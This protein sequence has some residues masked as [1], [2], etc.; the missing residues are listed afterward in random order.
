C[1]QLVRDL[2]PI[3]RSLTGDGVRETLAY[4]SRQLPGLAVHEIP[5]GTQVF[6][7]VVP[8]EWSIRDAYVLDEAGHRVIDFPANNLHVVGSSH[9]VD[10]WLELEELQTH[11]YSLPD[12]PDAI[13]YIPSY[14][15]PRWGFCLSHDQRETLRPGRYRAVI[16]SGLKPGVLNYADLILP[17]RS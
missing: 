13:P 16:D 15:A 4:L 5:S 14:Y 3:C 12:Q 17:G 8:D 9:P 10:Q 6:D 2:F 1:H 11:L 7:W